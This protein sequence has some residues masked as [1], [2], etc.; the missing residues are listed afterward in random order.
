MYFL[1]SDN[2]TPAVARFSAFIFQVGLLMLGLVPGAWAQAALPAYYSKGATGTSYQ[3][4]QPSSQV[5]GSGNVT[6]AANATNGDFAT[7]ATLKVDATASVNVPVGLLLKLTGTAPAGYRAG[8]VLANTASGLA[9]VSALGT[10]K[11]RTYLNGFTLAQRQEEKVVQATVLQ[12]LLLGAGTRPTQLEFITSKPFDAVEIE[13]SGVVGI[14]YTTNIYYAYG[15]RPG[16]QTSATGYLSRFATLTGSEYV[17]AS[18]SGL[19]CIATDVQNPSNV[20]DYDLTNFALLNTTVAVACNPSLR[21][22][23]AGV[24]VGGAPSVLTT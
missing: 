7:F 8:M 24:P 15:V 22:K 3:V 12:A 1:Y 11:L 20:A 17:A 5:A 10:G 23:L 18:A 6:A 19:L 13:F 9:N 21:T 14:N 2:G 16:V 4:T